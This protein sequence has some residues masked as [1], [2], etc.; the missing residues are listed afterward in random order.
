MALDLADPDLA[1][2]VGVHVESALG[3]QVVQPGPHLPARL[4][5]AD[6]VRPVAPTVVVAWTTDAE[7]TRSAL[8]AGALDVIAWPAD[9]DRL[10]AVRLDT[11]AVRPA[12]AVI[13]VAAAAPSIGCTTVALGLG[14]VAAW[15]GR[16]AVV[17]TSVAGMGM[18]G[19]REPGPV[20]GVGGLSVR[21]TA[22]G[23]DRPDVLVADLG[24]AGHRAQVLVARPDRALAQALRDRPQ[25]RTVVTVGQAGLRPAEVRRLVGDRALIALPWS[26]RVARA[27]VRGRVPVS[28]PGAW[29]APLREAL[30]VEARR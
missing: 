16:S 20:A 26:A 11:P 23:P 30:P 5:I 28:L 12:A 19:L 4:W 7:R 21:T 22:V 1:H 29:V 3:W 9:A 6:R 10:A 15:G 18:A 24:A 17:L 27:G 25:V 2:E 13:G 14:A 8:R